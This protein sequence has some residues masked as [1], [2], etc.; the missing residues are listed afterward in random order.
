M[1]IEISNILISTFGSAALIGGALW[2]ARN[3]LITRLTSAVSHEYNEK[4]AIINADLSSKKSEIEAL[5][6]GVLGSVVTRQRL[7]YERR[8]KAVEQLWDNVLDLG[9]AKQTSATILAIPYDKVLDHAEEEPKVQEIFKMIDGGVDGKKDLSFFKVDNAVKARPFLSE[10]AWSLFSAYTT[11]LSMAVLRMEMLKTGIKLP[12]QDAK[13]S[14][15]IVKKALPHQTEYID[16]YGLDG[17]HYLLE[18]LELSILSELRRILDGKDSD[19][20]SLEMAQ[21]INEAVK[22]L[23]S[24]V[25]EIK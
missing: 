12:L 25:S 20:E 15:D 24:S 7:L 4:L 8:L 2:L 19:K 18:E 17:M 5:R 11:I 3:L 13:S 10:L 16:K 6:N 9:P 22:E 1:T 21:S 23:Q 14:L